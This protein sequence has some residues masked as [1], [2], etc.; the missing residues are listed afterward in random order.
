MYTWGYLKDVSLSKLDMDEPEAQ[1]QNLLNK[2]PFYA[3]EAM[4]QICSTIKPKRS[5]VQFVI[6]KD[7]IGK[8]QTMPDDFVSFGDDVNTLTEIDEFGDRWIT[9]CHDDDLTFKGYNQLLFWKEGVYTVSYNARWYVF[10]MNI[11]N[12]KLI[13][14]PADVL[15]CIPS[16]IASQCYK[17]DDDVK[18][19]IF[20]NEYEMFL[21]RLDDTNYKQTKSFKIGG[22]W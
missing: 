4:T 18:A 3:N 11:D 7:L 2:F 22:D 21:A 12:N 16:Y 15:D 14:V 8:L 1:E 13:D 9:E 20:R 6:T 17:N 19:Q 10:V 5:F